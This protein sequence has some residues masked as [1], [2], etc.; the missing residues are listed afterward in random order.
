M[1]T[2]G[3]K[4]MPP[5]IHAGGLRYHGDS[6]IISQLVKEGL[7]EPKAYH[8][9]EVF[10]AAVMFAQTEGFIPAPETAHAIKAVIDE[11]IK[12]KEE[13]KEKCIVFNFSGHGHFDLKAYDLFF[14]NKLTNYYLEDKYIKE[15]EKIVE[16]I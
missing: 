13:A 3:H 7:V 6:P 4:F 16:Q 9:K 14:E 11:A 8:Q 15:A 5:E 2:L 10:E 1:Y 12:A